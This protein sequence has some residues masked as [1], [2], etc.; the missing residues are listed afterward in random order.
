MVAAADSDGKS[1][2]RMYYDTFLGGKEVT[3][4]IANRYPGQESM[5]QDGA[6]MYDV[7]NMIMPR[8]S[9]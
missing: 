4:W 6:S 2:M 9:P 3:A 1:G 5:H 8:H 7:M